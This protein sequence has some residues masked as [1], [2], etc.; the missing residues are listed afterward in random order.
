MLFA[1]SP[2]NAPSSAPMARS[3]SGSN[4]LRPLCASMRSNFVGRRRDGGRRGHRSPLPCFDSVWQLVQSFRNQK[5]DSGDAMNIDEI[6]NKPITT[7]E[8]P[9]PTEARRYLDD[10]DGF[11]GYDY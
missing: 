7:P 10:P 8:Y 4:R 5:E 3:A 1:A 9:D 2:P 6:I 11:Y